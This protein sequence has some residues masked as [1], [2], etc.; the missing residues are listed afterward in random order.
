[1]IEY[2]LDIHLTLHVNI[3]E[4]ERNPTFMEL[5]TDDHQMGLAIVEKELKTISFKMF[6]R[7]RS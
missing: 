3:R 1:M 7:S 4:N 6:L 5:I 2:T